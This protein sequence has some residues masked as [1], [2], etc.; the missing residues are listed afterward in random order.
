VSQRIVEAHGGSLEVSSELGVG[1][2][3]RVRLP[4]AA[5]ADASAAAEHPTGLH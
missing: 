4:L 3:F 1:S 2:T 5:P